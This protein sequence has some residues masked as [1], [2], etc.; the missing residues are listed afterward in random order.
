MSFAP[1]EIATFVGDG[2]TT[3]IPSKFYPSKEREFPG[4]NIRCAERAAMRFGPLTSVRW[5]SADDGARICCP[6]L[7]GHPVPG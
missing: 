4:M 2:Y 1:P 3:G 7:R 6:Q 5:A